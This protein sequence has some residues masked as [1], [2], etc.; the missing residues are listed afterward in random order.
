MFEAK[1]STYAICCPLVFLAGLVDAIGGGGGL[2]SLP[3]YLFAGLP[4]HTA[5][6]TNK[7][8]STF[9]TSLATARFAKNKLID[10]R[11]S[12]PAVIAAVAGSFIGANLSLIIS[13]RIFKIILIFALPAVAVIV[14]NK[15][16]FKDKEEKCGIDKKTYAA[17]FVAAFIIGIYD[18]MYG[19]GTGTFLLI[20]LNIFA[21]LSIKSANAQAKVINLTTNITSLVIFL[22]N[23]T[24]LIPLGIACALCNMAGSY[25]G[26]GM[27]LNKGSKIIRPIII[28]VLVILA[29]K[30][31]LETSGIV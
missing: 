20:A 13:E 1:I 14:L 24:V 17:A 9:G 19:P 7:L 23:G 5:V 21:G 4:A 3:A 6:S 8:S 31:I 18:G 12:L 10:L 16:L 30:L 29:L 11:L 15:R 22:L 26:S 25:I 2:I 27:V 28:S